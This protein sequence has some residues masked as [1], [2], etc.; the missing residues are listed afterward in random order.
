M[1]GIVEDVLE[2]PLKAVYTKGEQMHQ[3]ITKLFPF[4]RSI[5]GNGVRQT[6]DCIKQIIPLQIHEIPTG[7][8]V[9]DWQIPKEWNI[10]DAYIRSSRG[11]KVVDF[12]QSNLHILNYSVPVHRNIPL[13][14]LKQHLY[15]LPEH[16]DWIPYR[17]SYYKEDWGFCVNHNQYQQ[18]NDDRYEV[19]IDSTLEDGHLTYGE[20]FIPGEL[21]EEILI[22]THVCHPSLCNDNLSGISVATF[23]AKELSE[24]K[25]RYSFRFLFIPGTIGA[26]TW[27]ALNEPILK[28]V[29]HGLI[30]SLLGSTGAF[31]YKKSRQGNA[32]I[33]QIVAE[34]LKTRNVNYKIV[35]FSPYGYDERQFCSPGFNLPVG[36]LTRALYG[37]FQE[38][39]TSADNLHFI[40]PEALED[41]LWIYSEVM[42]MIERNKRYINLNPKGEPQLGRRGLYSNIGGDS[43]TKDFQLA[44]LWILNLSDAS[45][46]LLD[47]SKRSGMRFEAVH[48]AALLL[49][50]Y[51]L[52]EKVQFNSHTNF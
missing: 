16:P 20:F 11:E 26:I 25:S 21:R 6:L 7:T 24:K 12:K 33:D 36:C 32:E 40:K 19:H 17:T 1:Q 10:K 27:L 39:H 37:Q 18:I 52:L 8:K 48:K 46:S 41:S 3:F 29:K 45:Y 38:Y 47:I 28:Y 34:V 9:L 22:S 2:V 4:C 31:I 42:E 50:E 23:L 15:T 35:D 13:A 14:E 44:V 49:E 5:T 30:A 43:K 51:G